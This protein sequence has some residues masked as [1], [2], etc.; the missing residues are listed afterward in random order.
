MQAIAKKCTHGMRSKVCA[1]L[2]SQWGDEGN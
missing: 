1:I 2:G